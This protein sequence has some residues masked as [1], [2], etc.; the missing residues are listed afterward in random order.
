[1]D[2]AWLGRAR[3]KEDGEWIGESGGV[4]G[5]RRLVRGDLV[6]VYGKGGNEDDG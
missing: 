1:M 2:A 3:K 5:E 6:A 4:L